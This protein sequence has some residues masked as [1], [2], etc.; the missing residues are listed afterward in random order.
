MSEKNNTVEKRL[1]ELENPQDRNNFHHYVRPL[2]SR[3]TELEEVVEEIYK[4]TEMD[5][6]I[7]ENGEV[8]EVTEE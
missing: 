5:F 4:R 1:N 8:G 6:V 7:D 3:L 2:A